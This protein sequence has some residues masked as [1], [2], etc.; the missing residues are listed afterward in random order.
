M[1]PL[2]AC[3]LKLLQVSDGRRVLIEGPTALCAVVSLVEGLT[4]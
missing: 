2:H 4:A 1:L 3:T